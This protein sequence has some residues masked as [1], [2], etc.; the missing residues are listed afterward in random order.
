MYIVNSKNETILNLITKCERYLPTRVDR[1]ASADK[2]QWIGV[3]LTC[4]ENKSVM[5]FAILNFD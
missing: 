1:S 2:L 5:S 4:N 3:E